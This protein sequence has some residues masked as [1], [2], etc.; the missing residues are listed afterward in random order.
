MIATQYDDVHFRTAAQEVGACGYVLKENLFEV[1]GSSSCRSAIDEYT[2]CV[3]NPPMIRSFGDNATSDLYYGRNTR[4]ARRLP[5]ALWPVICRKLDYVNAALFLS[6][7]REPVGNRLEALKGKRKGYWSIRVNDQYRVT[8]RFE[9]GD[10]WDLTCED[11][12]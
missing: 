7:L 5:K 10:A 12:H 2:V 6:A 3:Y 9:D 8:F 4:A 11:Y 1:R